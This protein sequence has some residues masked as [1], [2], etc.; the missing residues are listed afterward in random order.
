MCGEQGAEGIERVRGLDER[1]RAITLG[2]PG[3][4]GLPLNL[5]PRRNV[6]VRHVRCSCLDTAAVLE[7]IRQQGFD[8]QQLGVATVGG[9]PPSRPSLGNGIDRI[10]DDREAEQEVGDGK[11]VD[12][13]VPLDPDGQAC[14]FKRCLCRINPQIACPQVSRDRCGQR[15]LAGPRLARDDDQGRWHLHGWTAC[16]AHLLIKA[17]TRHE[18]AQRLVDSLA[19][20]LS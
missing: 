20:G 8:L 18:H 9:V 17:R 7:P 16:R 19:S 13:G 5:L 10:D 15:R 3:H 2:V 11:L 14:S 1:A 4:P 6:L 12:H